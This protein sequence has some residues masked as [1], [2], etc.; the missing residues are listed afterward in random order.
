MK[1]TFALVAKVITVRA[2]IAI[3]SKNGHLIIQT[4]TIY[5][6]TLGI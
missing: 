4:L 5:F 3:P 6:G 2:L 1:E